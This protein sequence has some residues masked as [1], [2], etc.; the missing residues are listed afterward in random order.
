MENNITAYEWANLKPATLY[1][2]KFEFKQL[3]LDF[4]NVFQRL[5]VQVETGIISIWFIV[6]IYLVDNLV[7]V[8]FFSQVFSLILA[9]VNC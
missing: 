2:F 8:L 5:D 9:T 6:N 4:I 1:A 7:D 3:H